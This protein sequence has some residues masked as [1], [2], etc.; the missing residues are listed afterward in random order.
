M[1]TLICYS[2]KTGNTA[3]IALAIQAALPHADLFSVEDNPDPRDYDLVFFGF[4][5]DK[6]TADDSSKTYMQRLNKQSVALFATLGAYPDS[7]HA[8][9]SLENAA[10]LIPTC[11]VVDRFICQGAI[12]P[13]LIAWMSTLPEDHPH[14]PDAARIKRWD[15]AKQHPDNNDCANVAKWATA[16]ME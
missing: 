7:E 9:E 5:V 2:S 3:K 11:T 6:G 16:L 4:W 14:A 8:T 13:K 10:Q 15:D 1:K 12:D